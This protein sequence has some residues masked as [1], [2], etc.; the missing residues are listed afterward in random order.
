[1]SIIFGLD[2]NIQDTKE[3]V[4]DVITNDIPKEEIKVKEN[5]IDTV[6][7]SGVTE[8]PLTVKEN[9]KVEETVIDNSK[10]EICE[11]NFIQGTKVSVHFDVFNIFIELGKNVELNP[12]DKTL[13]VFYSGKITQSN[14][15]Y[16][17]E[18]K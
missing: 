14:F 16:W 18:E 5:I 8:N 13:K 6:V 7:K 3:G 2:K 12:D 4:E 10:F 1:V 9:V 11:I 15:K 17:I